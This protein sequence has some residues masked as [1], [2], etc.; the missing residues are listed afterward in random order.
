MTVQ[1]AIDYLK[2]NGYTYSE[3]D[4]THYLHKRTVSSECQCKCFN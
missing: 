3:E 1:E 4:D 2:D